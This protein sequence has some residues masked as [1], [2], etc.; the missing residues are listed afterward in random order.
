MLDRLRALI[1]DYRYRRQL[2]RWL[3]GGEKVQEMPLSELR[4]LRRRANQVRRRIDT[5]SLT[6]RCHA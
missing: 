6:S 3:G 5:R 1:D 2:R 4:E